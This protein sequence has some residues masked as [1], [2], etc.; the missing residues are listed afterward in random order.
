MG[1]R[2]AAGSPTVFLLTAHSCSDDYAVYMY[3]KVTACNS[4]RLWSCARFHVFV[5]VCGFVCGLLVRA[6]AVRCGRGGLAHCHCAT[7]VALHVEWE[8]KQRR[9]CC[10]AVAC[11][12]L[13]IF[14]CAGCWV[15]GSSVLPVS[16]LQWPLQ[17]HM[18]VC[19][20]NMYFK[21]QRWTRS[22]CEGMGVA[23]SSFEWCCCSVC[24]AARCCVVDAAVPTVLCVLYEFCVA[25]SGEG[26]TGCDVH[27][28]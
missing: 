20:L 24:E 25:F 1:V 23:V 7:I 6:D 10:V 9:R 16:P 4:Q 17:L 11:G 21:W 12:S 8:L 19:D 5:C 26:V 18:A 13:G 2:A 22:H 27:A 28:L 14:H 3:V 15:S